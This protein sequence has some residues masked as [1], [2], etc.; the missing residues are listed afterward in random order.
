MQHFYLLKI[1]N[2]TT[3]QRFK[4]TSDKF[5]AAGVYSEI[6][7]KSSSLSYVI[8][9]Y[10]LLFP[11]ER[12]RDRILWKKVFNKSSTRNL[13]IYSK[14]RP[15]VEDRELNKIKKEWLPMAWCPTRVPRKSVKSTFRSNAHALKA[16]AVTEVDGNVKLANKWSAEGNEVQ[17]ITWTVEIRFFVCLQISGLQTTL[18]QKQIHEWD[19]V[20]S[21]KHTW[22]QK[23]TKLKTCL[24]EIHIPLRIKINLPSYNIKMRFISKI[25]QS[26][27]VLNE[28]KQTRNLN[29]G[30]LLKLYII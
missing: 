4:L 22:L 2:T 8:N 27:N 6:T 18:T 14:Q 1:T 20:Q 12:P 28:L 16:G 19:C 13:S 29:G 11:C 30:H 24:K 10:F 23:I 15:I 25:Q 17:N 26:F 5:N 9:L 7:D 3:A 21:Y